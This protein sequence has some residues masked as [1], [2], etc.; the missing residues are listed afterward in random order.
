LLS[1]P[2]FNKAFEIEYDTSRIGIGVVLMQEKQPIADANQG[3]GY[4]RG[5]GA[6]FAQY[7]LSLPSGPIT[8]L[9]AKR[10]KEALNGLIQENLAD[11]KDQDGL[12]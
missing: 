11:S 3:A 2:D 12:K 1:L 10:F 7:P 5:N 4:T 9:K 6:K 8:R